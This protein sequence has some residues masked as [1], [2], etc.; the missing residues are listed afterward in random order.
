MG[1]FIYV[2]APIHEPTTKMW[3]KASTYTD[4]LFS[5]YYYYTLNVIKYNSIARLHLNKYAVLK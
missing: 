3:K 5:D 1:F 4:L 2:T